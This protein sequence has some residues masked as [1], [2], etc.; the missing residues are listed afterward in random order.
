LFSR[1]DPV[2][3]SDT[4]RYACSAENTVGIAT[5]TC[6]VIVYESKWN[7]FLLYT[8]YWLK[9][10]LIYA[11]NSTKERIP[12]L[13][14]ILRYRVLFGYSFQSAIFFLQ[15]L[16]VVALERRSTWLRVPPPNHLCSPH[17]LA[18]HKGWCMPH[19]ITQYAST[20]WSETNNR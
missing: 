9:E 20:G 12:R 17:T 7:I 3:L 8:F 1:I 5:T 11:K 16:P 6:D 19:V 13:S 2:Q 18:S 14:A 15:L 10:V 4:G